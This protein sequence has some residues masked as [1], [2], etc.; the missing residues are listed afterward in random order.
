[1]IIL[2]KCKQTL[3]DYML[4]CELSED[5]WASIFIQII[6]QLIAY[7]NMFDFTHNDLHTNNVMYVETNKEFVNYLYNDKYYKVPT[8][9]KIWKIIDFGRAIFKFKKHIFC[10]DSFHPKGDAAGQYNCKPFFNLKKE[11]LNPN[12]S[13]DICRLGCS[14]FDYFFEDI[15]DVNKENLTNIEKLIIKWCL[16][17]DERNLL[18]KKMVEKDILN[19]NYIR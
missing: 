11:E 6:F 17:D 1:M 14:L 3:D 9:G 5:E 2:E 10:S 12:F 16:D 18:Y 13:F 19:L 4:A 15:D 7:Q 8:Y